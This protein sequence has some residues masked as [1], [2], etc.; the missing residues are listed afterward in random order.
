MAETRLLKKEKL[1]LIQCSEVK[2]PDK[3]TG[4]EITKFKYTFLNEAN[5]VINGYL[6]DLKFQDKISASG[7]YE[8]KSA[9][10]FIWSGREW[11]RKM[12]FTLTDLEPKKV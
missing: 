1:H 9:W 12:K 7:E 4:E 5:E 2:F 3:V 8:A 10:M 11:D 6:P